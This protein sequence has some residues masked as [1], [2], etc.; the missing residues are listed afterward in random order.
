MA[1]NENKLEAQV[2]EIE[3]LIIHNQELRKNSRKFL[4]I[5]TVVLFVIVIFFVHEIYSIFERYYA[6][7][8]KV[9]HDK[10]VKMLVQPESP[11]PLS[12][13]SDPEIDKLIFNL[14]KLSHREIKHSIE[15]TQREI[16]QRIVPDFSQ[17]L[18]NK[19]KERE[20]DFVKQADDAITNLNNHA[21]E[22]I[23]A[24]LLNILVAGIA[25]TEKELLLAFPQLEGKDI[26]TMI[27][28]N[29][30]F[31]YDRIQVKIE[32]KVARF[33][34]FLE[35]INYQVTQLSEQSDLTPAEAEL[36]REQIFDDFLAATLDRIKYEFIPE[37]GEELIDQEEFAEVEVTEV[38]VTEVEV[39]EVKEVTVE[40]EK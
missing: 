3:K 26:E 40:E 14:S 24:D 33:A 22:K 19:F 10:F 13:V 5:T 23:K 16:K 31:L 27:R 18:V 2:A 21:Q 17:R 37:L 15:I 28:S 9:N 11:T 12:N 20:D 35:A 4:F 25:E 29:E 39:T 32:E 38:E 36:L 1:T 8:D 7:F 34:P 30:A 6:Y